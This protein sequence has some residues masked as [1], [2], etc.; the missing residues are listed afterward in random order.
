MNFSSESELKIPNNI[1]LID[2]IQIKQKFAIFSTIPNDVIFDINNI[3]KPI[4]CS[5]IIKQINSNVFGFKKNDSVAYL[6]HQKTKI[7]NLSSNLVIKL[8]KLNKDILAVLPYASYAMKILREINP[9]I[10]QN[11]II[12][13]LNFFS[14]LLLKIFKLAGSYPL[15]INIDDDSTNQKLKIKTDDWVIEG[16][17]EAKN[18]LKNIKIDY[19]VVCT[20]LKKNIDDFLNELTFRKRFL[21]NDISI[22][23]KGIQDLNYIRGIKYPYPYVR[24]DFKNNINYFINM[25]EKDKLFLDFL[26]YK[27][28]EIE[29]ILEIPKIINDLQDKLLVLFSILK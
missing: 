9:K 18:R 16:S 1:E 21:L 25:I 8:K 29:S 13:G 19:I 7:I 20:H 11:I 22:Y 24:W 5:G 10:G 2:S 17:N 12:F 27:F 23:D 4:F 14:L 28:L 6:S 15:I 26:D 3:N